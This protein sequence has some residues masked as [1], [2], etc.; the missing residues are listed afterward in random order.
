MQLI[1]IT[2]SID[3]ATPVYPGDASLSIEQTALEPAIVSAF[4][5][6]PHLGTHVDAPMHLHRQGDISDIDCARLLGLCQVVD[7][8]RSCGAIIPEDFPCIS[9]KRVL[10]RTG[11]VAGDVWDN[12]FAYLSTDSVQW[13][14]SQGVDVIGIDIEAVNF[15]KEYKERVFSD[16]LREYSAGRTPNPDVLCNAEIKFRA[17]L[18]YAMNMGAECIAT[19]HYARTRIGP[20]GKTQLLRGLDETKDQSYFLHRLSQEQISKVIFPVGELRKTQVRKIAEE[21]SNKNN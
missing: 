11:F 21:T 8:P 9:Q 20:D 4:R 12:A 1:D 10:I 3:E 17:F 14:I 19:G 16:F 2:Q 7:I 6:S 18:D 15:A 5:M 13:L